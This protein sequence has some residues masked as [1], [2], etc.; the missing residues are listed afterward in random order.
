MVERILQLANLPLQSFNFKLVLLVLFSTFF[1]VP[2]LLIPTN[3]QRKGEES[4]KPPS[5]MVAKHVASDKKKKGHSTNSLQVASTLT[6]QRAIY[7]L[8]RA[9]S[10]LK[11]VSAR[12]NVFTTSGAFPL[13]AL[14]LDN[15]QDDGVK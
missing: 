10:A 13:N 15:S 9:L 4:R 5:L 6:H 14:G 3:K 12:F 8:M 11:S 2:L 1:P 7:R